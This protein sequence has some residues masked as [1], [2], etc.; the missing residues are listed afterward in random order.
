MSGG[1]HSGITPPEGNW[2]L[3]IPKAE[4]NWIIVSFIWCMCLFAFM[5]LW[6]YFGEVNPAGVRGR[7]DPKAFAERTQ[8]FIDDYQV[9]D[10]NGKP[11]KEKGIPVVEPPP[12]ADVYLMAYQ[13]DWTPVLKLKKGVEY[14]VHIS[15][16]DVGH[17]FSLY[18]HNLNLQIVPGYD[19]ALR[20]TPTEVIKPDGYRII[21]NEFCGIGH[22]KMVGKIMVEE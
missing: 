6:H 21:C 2:W 17:G 4:K 1:L 12:G 9:K 16:K 19:Y 3:P 14:T 18:P 8:R 11:V 13:W 7:V 15:S 20:M 22:H 5:P 10:E